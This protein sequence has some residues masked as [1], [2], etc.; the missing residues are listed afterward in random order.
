MGVI[1]LILEGDWE[2]YIP[3][4]PSLQREG[5][6]FVLMRVCNYAWG[7]WINWSHPGLL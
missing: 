7:I 5:A 1:W 2:K 6:C 3:S 4:Q